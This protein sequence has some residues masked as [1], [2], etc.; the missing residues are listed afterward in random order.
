MGGKS[1][2]SRR[3]PVP[4]STPALLQI[5]TERPWR[6]HFL[7]PNSP[8]IQLVNS[9]DKCISAGEVASLSFLLIFY[10]CVMRH[11]SLRRE[12]I[13]PTPPEGGLVVALIFQRAHLCDI[14]LAARINNT[15]KA[16]PIWKR[17]DLQLFLCTRMRCSYTNNTR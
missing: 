12:H 14:P 6:R 3:P 8:G 11:H 13:P 10:M 2:V 5:C 7:L 9:R 4:T 17:S 1:N 15:H 16:P